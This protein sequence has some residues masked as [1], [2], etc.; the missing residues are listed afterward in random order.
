[1]CACFGYI[2]ILE[3]PGTD[4]PSPRLYHVAFDSLYNI[5]K[6]KPPTHP[7]SSFPTI[8]DSITR[9]QQ[10]DVRGRAACSG[11]E[12]FEPSSSSWNVLDLT[13]SLFP[14]HGNCCDCMVHGWHASVL[15]STLDP[16]DVGLCVGFFYF[17]FCF[18]LDVCN[19]FIFFLF[20]N[21]RQMHQSRNTRIFCLLKLC[22]NLG[23][24]S[25]ALSVFPLSVYPDQ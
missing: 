14:Q 1:M 19:L 25:S 24:L 8:L 20:F 9:A 7:S 2:R 22:A 15:S 18:C 11:H 4:H 12:V 10:Q 3:K 5:N 13:P 16:D 21:T 23:S 17:I 6:L